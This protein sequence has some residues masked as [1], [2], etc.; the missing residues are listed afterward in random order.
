[1]SSERGQFSLSR[2]KLIKQ[3]LEWGSPTPG[4]SI[5]GGPLPLR[6]R[7]SQQEVSSRR[8]SK[9][10]SVFPA[11]S[12]SQHH[13]HLSSASDPWALGSHKSTGPWVHKGWDRFP[14]SKAVWWHTLTNCNWWAE[15]LK[16]SINYI[17]IGAPKAPDSLSLPTSF[18]KTFSVKLLTHAP[19]VLRLTGAPC[20]GS[21]KMEAQV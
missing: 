2:G 19:G 9:A 17:T 13:H 21:E 5:G 20:S 6:I 3:T 4:S 7:V 18:K 10:S 16:D 12:E 11:A 15:T 14:R 8:A 1:M